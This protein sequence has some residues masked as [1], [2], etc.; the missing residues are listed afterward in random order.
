MPEVADLSYERLA[1]I[2]TA[3]CQLV[4]SGVD[5]TADRTLSSEIWRHGN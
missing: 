4:D 1:S 5:I 3:A 2:R